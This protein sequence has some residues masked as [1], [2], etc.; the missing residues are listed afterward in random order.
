MSAQLLSE[1][2]RRLQISN[3]GLFFSVFFGLQPP[4]VV[5]QYRG[6][7][8]A[9]GGGGGRAVSRRLNIYSLLIT[10]FGDTCYHVKC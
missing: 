2:V 3:S 9:V 6:R 8:L 4:S 5:V 1:G 10:Y 7:G